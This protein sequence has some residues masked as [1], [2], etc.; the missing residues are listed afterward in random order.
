MGTWSFRAR[1]GG[2]YT[3]TCVRARTRAAAGGGR[4][5]GRCRARARAW[6]RGPWARARW[7]VVR[8]PW[9]DQSSLPGSLFESGA[10]NPT[11]PR[12]DSKTPTGVR[13]RER[14]RPFANRCRKTD[15]AVG[16]LRRFGQ[17]RRNC[18]EL[19]DENTPPERYKKRSRGPF[20]DTPN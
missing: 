6:V 20:S 2:N 5:A 11:R 18:W 19:A 8:G 10:V 17:N 13:P 14:I 7:S 1:I 15:R 12:K 16:R 4:P 9:S 3:R